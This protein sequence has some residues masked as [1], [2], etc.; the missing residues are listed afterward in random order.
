VTRLPHIGATRLQ[1]FVATLR[2]HGNSPENLN[3]ER[4]AI[5]NPWTSADEL[6]VEF[7]IQQNGSRKLPEE[8]AASAL[9]VPHNEEGEE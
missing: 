3:L 8:V 5:F 2:I 7:R 6:L 1:N 9:P 4:L